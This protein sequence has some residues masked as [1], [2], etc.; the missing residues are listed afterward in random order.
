ME[1]ISDG[2]ATEVMHVCGQSTVGAIL[3]VGMIPLSSQLKKAATALKKDPLL[4]ALF[5]GDDYEMV[6]TVPPSAA[7]KIKGSVVGRITRKPGIFLTDGNV[8]RPLRKHGFE[9]FS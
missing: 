5:G 1:D 8:S 3:N 4:F 6:F 9:H 7:S 2:L